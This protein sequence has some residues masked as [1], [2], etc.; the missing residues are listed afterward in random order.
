MSLESPS[1]CSRTEAESADVADGHVATFHLDG[2]TRILDRR[3][4]AYR[5]DVADVALAGTLFAPHYAA[6]MLRQCRAPSAMMRNAANPQAEA[7]SQLLSGE[8]FAVLDLTAGWAWGYSVSDHYVGYVEAD[9][10]DMPTVASHIVAVRE[11]LI[12]SE[13]SIKS[14]LRGTLPFG[15]RIAAREECPFFAIEGGYIHHRHVR[16]AHERTGDPVAIAELFL[17]MP[18]LWGGRG[19]RGID[20]SGLVQVAMAAAGIAL[21][22]DTDQQRAFPCEDLPAEV[23]LRRGDIICFPGHVGLMVDEKLLIHANAHWMAVVIEP[24]SDV[25]ARLAPNHDRPILARRRI[26]I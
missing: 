2:P 1:I 18:Y 10:L 12:F 8:P 21:P 24:L 5:A 14:A 26:S 6:P 7:V 17:G 20:C 3:T 22:R 16:L 15:A 9:L 25:V 4:H 13:P 11:A 23:A 19:A